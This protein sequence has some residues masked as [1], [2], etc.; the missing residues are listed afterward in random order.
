MCVCAHK[1]CVCSFWIISFLRC[2]TA[3]PQPFRASCHF[4]PFEPRFGDG[5]FEP[6]IGTGRGWWSSTVWWLEICQTKKRDND[7]QK[8]VTQSLSIEWGS[9]THVVVFFMI[10]TWGPSTFRMNKALN[11]SGATLTLPL[12]LPQTCGACSYYAARISPDCLGNNFVSSVRTCAKNVPV[13][14]FKWYC[15]QTNRLGTKCFVHFLPRKQ[16]DV[17]YL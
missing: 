6:P 12:L 1:T 17:E 2:F 8:R 4:G 14:L 5:P 16:Q 13:F 9:K 7:Q 10:G 11:N 3:K 15:S